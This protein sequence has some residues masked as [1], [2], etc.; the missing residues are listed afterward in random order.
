MP[1]IDL[2]SIQDIVR[3]A[4]PEGLLAANAPQDEYEPEEEEIVAELASLPAAEIT[5]D[6]VH[7]V[8]TSI[9]EAAFD[10]VSTPERDAALQT[11]TERIVHFFGPDS[12]Y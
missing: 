10:A 3:A 11:I 8:V 1:R 4:D 9:W 5:E 7:S 6:L 12:V 2:E